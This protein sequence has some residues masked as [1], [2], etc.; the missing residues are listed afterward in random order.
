MILVG[1]AEAT[2]NLELLRLLLEVLTEEGQCFFE[3]PNHR[4]TLLFLFLPQVLF[5]LFIA[6]QQTMHAL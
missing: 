5:L 1:L 6:S 2:A 3:Q 4:E